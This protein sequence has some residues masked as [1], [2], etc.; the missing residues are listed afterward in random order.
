MG[1]CRAGEAKQVFAPCL[2]IGIQ[3]QIYQEKPEVGI[4]TPINWFDS[5]NDSFFAGMKPTLHKSQVHSNSVM[6]WW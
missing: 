4:L 1:V 2:E 5:C 6:Q 3:N